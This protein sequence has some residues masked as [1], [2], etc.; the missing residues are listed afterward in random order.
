MYSKPAVIAL[1]EGQRL[2]SP[3]SQDE[4]TI[5]LEVSCDSQTG[6]GMFVGSFGL[7]WAVPGSVKANRCVE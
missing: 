1:V 5:A 3:D 6:T 7:H 4:E 2:L